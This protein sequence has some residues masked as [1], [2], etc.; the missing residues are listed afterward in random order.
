MENFYYALYSILIANCPFDYSKRVGDHMKYNITLE[1][2]GDFWR[3]TVSGPGLK[4]DYA[5]AV[6]YNQQ[7][8]PKEIKNYHWIERAIQQAAE[9]SG[10][11]IN[12]E[13][14]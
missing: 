12:Y 7:R 6:N 11:N 3:I 14:S 4:Y 10:A 1:D 5:A 13:L 9:V 2:Y 8:G